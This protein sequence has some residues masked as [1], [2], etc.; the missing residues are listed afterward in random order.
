M[1]MNW[2]VNVNTTDAVCVKQKQTALR[3]E[4]TGHTK[5]AAFTCYHTLHDARKPSTGYTKHATV[6]MLP[7]SHAGISF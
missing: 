1:N 3:E 5:H 4:T 7:H 6:P 2:C